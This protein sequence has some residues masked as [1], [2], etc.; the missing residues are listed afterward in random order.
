[1]IEILKTT[2]EE[3]LIAETET[4]KNI[5]YRNRAKFNELKMEND[6][7]LELAAL[8]IF[9]NRTCFNG[10]YRVNAKGNYNV[11]QGRYKNPCICD[12]EN[13]RAVSNRLINVTIVNGNYKLS[14]DFID[15]KT[16]CYFDP[17]YRPLSATASFTAYAKDIFDDAAQTELAQF[18]DRMSERRASIVA[19]NSDPKNIDENDNF[20]DLLYVRHEIFRIEAHRT[21]NAIGSGRGKINE[22]LIASN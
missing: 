6:A 15:D 14:Q 7:S 21:I 5:Y 12:E 4:R 8:F 1:L 20:F 2:E 22:L 10:L 17:P 16:F 11:P 19:S 3:Y 9:L 13:L 18:I